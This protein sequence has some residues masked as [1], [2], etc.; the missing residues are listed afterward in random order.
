M[1]DD[2]VAEGRQAEGGVDHEAFG[3][4]EAEV[5]VDEGDPQFLAGGHRVPVDSAR[6]GWMHLRTDVA[7][8][9]RG[10]LLRN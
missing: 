3:A 9:A 10:C 6:V 8:S 4:A 5:G 2:G 7:H 1:D